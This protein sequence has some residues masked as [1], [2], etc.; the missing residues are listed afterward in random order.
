[1]NRYLF[2]LLTLVSYLSLISCS[3]SESTEEKITYNPYVEAFTSG[4]VS[5]Y[6]T[7]TC[8]LQEEIPAEMQAEGKWKEHVQLNPKAE[9]TFVLE[10]GRIVKFKPAGCLERDTR[11]TLT[12]DL[13]AW[14][15][16]PEKKYQRFSASFHTK[17][18]EVKAYLSSLEMN[19][20]NP[21]NYNLNYLVLTSDRELPATVEQLVGPSSGLKGVWQHGA[22]GKKHVL[23]LENI[24][25]GSEEV[26]LSV[27]PNKWNVAEETLVS[28]SV[29]AKDDFSVFDVQYVR[30]PERYVEVTFTQALKKDQVLDGLAY[31]EDNV[32][33]LVSVEGN[34]LRLYPD[35]NRNGDLKVVLKKEIQSTS[36]TLLA[37]DETREIREN[38]GCPDV[39]FMGDGV[40][41]PQSDKLHVPFQAI[42]LKGVVVRVV[43]IGE[44]NIG[45]FL[46]TNELDGTAELMRL[47]RLITR[48]VIFFD[49]H[50]YD[51]TRWNTFALDLKQ[52][53][54]P[55]PGAIYRVILSF[56]ESLSAY[57]C[58]QLETKTKEQI[59]AENEMAFR[60]ELNQ[61]DAG[62]W[63]Y[64]ESL[65]TDWSTY[66]YAERN[67]PCSPS[68]YFNRSAGKNILVS[69]I[70]LMAM[71]GTDG[72][73][74]VLAHHL[75]TTEPMSGVQIGA[76][77][78]QKELLAEGTT[79]NDGRVVFD[80]RKAGGRPYYLL[81]SE[82]KQRSYLRVNEGSNLSLS[83]FDVD[84]EV[85]QK[86]IK[87][88]IYGERG[89][90]RPGDT[91]HVGFMLFDRSKMLPPHHPVKLSLFNPLGQVYQQK[92]S[93]QGS[94]G[95]Y[96]FHI[97]TEAS[98][99]TG[100]WNVKVE[101]GGVS[102]DKRLRVESIKPNRLKIRLDVPDL[103]VREQEVAI[104]LHV[105]WLQGAKAR[106]LKYDVKGTFVST[107]TSFKNYPDYTFDNPTVS[108][109]S[110]E[111]QLITGTTNGEGD[112]SV[113]TRLNVGATAPGMLLGSFT[114]KVYEESG[115]FSIDAVR[116]L[117]SPYQRYVG[118][119]SPQKNRQPLSTDQD[120]T[121][122]LVSVDYHGAPIAGSELDISIYKLDWY[123]WWSADQSTLAN[124][125]SSSY[126]KPVKQEKLTTDEAGKASLALSF[127][128]KNWGTYLILAKDRKSGHTTGVVSYF[129]WPN[130]NRER[131]FSG[132]DAASMLEFKLD[133]DSYVP[134]EDIRITIPSSAGS[135]AVV[136]VQTGSTVLLVKEFKCEANQTTFTIQATEEMQPNAYLFVSLLQPHGATAN[137]MPIRMFGVVPFT[138]ISE[139]SHLHPQL[140]T[141]KEWKPE[142]TCQVTV[143]E[144]NGRAMSYTLAVVD[145]GLLDL[146]R[147]QTP[148]PWKTFYAREALGVDTWDLYNYILGA[149]GG[150]IEQLF[151]IGGD[152]ALNKGPKAVVNRFAPVVKF[153]GPFQ[154]KKGERKTHQIDIP[155]YNGR[156]RVMA[157]ATNG[158]SFGHTEQS[159]MVRKP[160][161]LLGTL[162]R[163]VG[164]NEE[165]VIPATV[166]ATEDNVGDVAVSL[167]CSADVEMVGETTRTLHFTKK[168]DKTVSFRIKV[169]NPVDKIRITM[170]AEGKGEVSTYAADLAVRTVTTV[171]RKG[172]DAVIKPGETWKQPVQLSGMNGSN[173]LLL[174][175]SSIQPLNLS[176][177]LS[178]L[179]D[180]PHACLEQLVSK[181]FP[182]LYLSDVSEQ[183]ADQVLEAE[184]QVKQIISRLRSYQLPTG[185]FAYW[186]GQSNSNAWGSIYALHF[187]LMAEGKGYAVPATL[188]LQALADLQ[189]MAS[190]WK[191]VATGYQQ[192][193]E[194]LTQAYRLYVLALANKADMGAMNRLRAQQPLPVAAQWMLSASYAVVGRSDV[195][196]TLLEKTTEN[197][198]SSLVY[199]ETFGSAFRNEAI[200]LVALCLVKEQEEATTLVTR[201]AKKLA[202][203]D[204]LST[205]ETAFAWVALAGYYQQYPAK[206][207]SM[208]FTYQYAEQQETVRTEKSVWSDRLLEGADSSSSDLVIKNEGETTLYVQAESLAEIPQQDVKESQHK[209]KLSVTYQTTDGRPLDIAS[210][211]QGTNFT[212]QV[213][214]QNPTALPLRNLVLTE[215][216]PS[217]WEI[218][219]TRFMPTAVSSANSNVSYQDIRDDRV[220]SYVDHLA[221]GSHV[222]VRVNLCAVYPGKFYLPPVSCEAM[223][224]RQIAAN[225]ASGM[226]EVK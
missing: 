149:Y 219:N 141:A 222:L 221:P 91:I 28:T 64:Q 138:V 22:D 208:Q 114:T 24:V 69:N 52:L 42:A 31:I 27:L 142:S 137:D 59:L 99:P 81:A 40:I 205:Q 167:Q 34:K 12:V 213:L 162:P 96:V 155:N 189:K 154:L 147:F 148:D 4:L 186:P 169:K 117:Y 104:P 49:E 33:K 212:A 61:F 204:W 65:N 146:T 207:G 113:R 78:Y 16:I 32:S 39:R 131:D 110:E 203:D 120:H 84:G 115:D 102:F 45:Q 101:V 223:Y 43:K 175:V 170:K 127:D 158:E 164:T 105:E 89:V 5:R 190:G 225:T 62:G 184:Q 58:P 129:D 135:R 209:L 152:D 46:Q 202:S 199:D 79:D 166:F 36:G 123:W 150:R 77:N 226:V 132:T 153:I 1:M 119:H 87:G 224:D 55:E 172:W 97:P 143:S 128:E 192:E 38:D 11:Y 103:L 173:R 139:E 94:D 206:T 111:S 183:T 90:W 13:A 109:N 112:A 108:F 23:T 197:T 107:G 130:I 26:S 100:A 98:V 168:E 214:I 83:S 116:L 185:S 30:T 122:Q 182:Q 159:V 156:V 6:V 18:L 29:P 19:P 145:E 218:L 9:G 57:D 20:S 177:R 47:G 21:G 8:I 68:Y 134:G 50:N 85:V 133:K 126:Y 60:E 195:A 3:F 196:K 161:M 93:T 14:K 76:Y 144:Q 73:M 53:I 17:A 88:F 44:Q 106:N 171:Q 118:I 194:M 37:K 7:P 181:G 10:E 125:T 217:G 178:E 54:D 80:C 48:Q 157:V 25:P 124:F 215:I 140:A 72:K 191:P 70:G 75:Q 92:V 74:V 200:R 220:C 151:S 165:I 176:A 95:L 193:A 82:G 180:Y 188:K 187:L 136:S 86:G 210:L 35:Q 66:K 163:V 63:Y 121:F 201:L 15:S 160:V 56:D 51:L 2:C 211:E 71:A 67:D 198:T 174:D 179:T 216:F 41:I